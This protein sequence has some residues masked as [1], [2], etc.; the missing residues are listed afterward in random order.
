MIFGVFSV[1]IKIYR[2]SQR[3]ILPTK[4]KYQKYRFYLPCLLI[5]RLL[6]YF[7]AKF[8]GICGVFEVCEVLADFA[9]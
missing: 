9:F 3:H 5:T 1:F 8:G 6:R 7:C 2:K 4:I